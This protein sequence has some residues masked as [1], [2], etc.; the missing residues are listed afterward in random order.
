MEYL[1]LHRPG[2]YDPLAAVGRLAAAATEA[3]SEYLIYERDGVWAVALEPLM[4]IRLDAH[5]L[6]TRV[7]GHTTTRPVGPCP[8]AQLRRALVTSTPL[9]GATAYGWV[10]FEAAYLTHPGLAAALTE[11]TGADPLM[12]M[13]VPR[14]DVRIDT[15]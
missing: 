9:T 10:A 13:M 2:R 7:N 12:R 1:Q 6:I 14:T 3:G 15:H 8:F 11:K 5:H 4:D